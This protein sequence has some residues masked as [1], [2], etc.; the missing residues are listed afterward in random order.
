MFVPRSPPGVPVAAA[1]LVGV[2]AGS[3]FALGVQGDCSQPLSTGARPVASDCLF[4]LRVA[5]GLQSCTPQPCICDPTGDASTTATDALTCLKNV[6]GESAA[7]ECPCDTTTSTTTTT[8][9]GGG[10]NCTDDGDCGNDDC[11][12]SDCDEDFFCKDPDNCTDN[13]TCQTFVEGCV[14]ADCMTHPECLDN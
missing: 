7:L 6:V 11:V 2:L 9:P 1:L 5:V 3:R 14:C 10:A 8:V 4:I 12:C 13:G